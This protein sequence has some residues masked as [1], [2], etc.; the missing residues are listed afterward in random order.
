MDNQ[1]R[2]PHVDVTRLE[3]DDA[4]AANW[5][6]PQS[7]GDGTPLMHTYAK[8]AIY[9]L[10]T[11]TAEGRRQNA[12]HQLVKDMFGR[13]YRGVTEEQ[14]QA[15]VWVL[16][17]GYG[18]GLW[19][20]EMAR[21]YPNG[22]YF[23]VDIASSQWAEAFQ[24]VNHEHLGVEVQFMRGDI[25]KSLPFPDNTFNYIHQSFLAFSI[26]ADLWPHALSELQRVLKPGGWVDLLEHDPIPMNPTPRVEVLNQLF[27]G[28]YAARG[29][30]L[31][32]P[33]QLHGMLKADRRF[34][35]VEHSEI[36]QSLGWEDNVVSRMW[37]EDMR[38]RLYNG[39]GFQKES[40]G[41]T[42]EEHETLIKYVCEDWITSKANTTLVSVCIMELI[43][44]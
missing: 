18:T 10:P 15:G 40:M 29:V 27:R 20:C 36:R 19:L 8:D 12:K 22:R 4:T 43:V 5:D 3:L 44:S 38:M 14:L 31:D 13:N 17:V 11:D 34:D 16:D 21:D 41:I 33:P 32:F 39:A 26:P 1:E 35:L 9:V 25:L 23:G 6:G 30:D 28:M 42:D 37:Y 24:R 7:V 2:L